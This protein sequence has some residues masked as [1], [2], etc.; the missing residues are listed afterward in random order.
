MPLNILEV[1]RDYE[2]AGFNNR[3]VYDCLL[4]LTE[5]NEFNL[6]YPVTKRVAVKREFRT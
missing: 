6:K 3:Y 2:V 1:K 4:F 5:N